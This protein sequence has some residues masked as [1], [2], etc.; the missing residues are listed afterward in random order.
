MIRASTLSS[1]LDSTVSLFIDNSCNHE[2]KVY[3]PG[4]LISRNRF[5]FWHVIVACY[6]VVLLATGLWWIRYIINVVH[7]K[8]KLEANNHKVQSEVEG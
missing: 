4:D 8:Q 3:T 1:E 6:T 7:Y 2:V 5:V